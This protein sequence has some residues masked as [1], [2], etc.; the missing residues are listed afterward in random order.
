[1]FIVSRT[2]LKRIKIKIILITPHHIQLTGMA[3]V[4][5][6]DNAH[7]YIFLAVHCCCCYHCCVPFAILKMNSS[8]SYS[9]LA[10]E[11][12]ICRKGVAPVVLVD[13]TWG[14]AVITCCA[15]RMLVHCAVHCFALITSTALSAAFLWL[16][17][18]FD[19]FVHQLAL[20]I[21]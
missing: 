13:L 14:S 8:F 4:G 21:S 18:L 15:G 7:L 10:I 5:R 19:S 16:F 2:S 17:C 12:R 1:M 9:S 20:A 11:T 3:P 6:S